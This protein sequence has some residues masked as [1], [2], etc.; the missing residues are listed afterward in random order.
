VIEVGGQRWLVAGYGPA[1]WVLNTRAQGNVTLRR[2][3]HSQT[4]KVE[5]VGPDAAI[6]VILWASH[7]LGLSRGFADD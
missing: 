7:D 4:Y 2:G 5:E 3:G 1:N 6:P